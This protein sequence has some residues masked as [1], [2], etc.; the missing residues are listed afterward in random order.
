MF[1]FQVKLRYRFANQSPGFKG[2]FEAS[3]HQ[4]RGRYCAPENKK[5]K[6]NTQ[7][8]VLCL[9]INCGGGKFSL[10]SA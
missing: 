5:H 2:A 6:L 8:I 10:F 4:N 1:V 7:R 9:Y 3:F